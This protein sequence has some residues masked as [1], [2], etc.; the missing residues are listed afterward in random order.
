MYP[1]LVTQAGISIMQRV[2]NDILA[3][4][5]DTQEPLT[6]SGEYY[7]ANRC[8][9]GKD[10]LIDSQ[11]HTRYGEPTYY[12]ENNRLHL[13][14]DLLVETDENTRIPFMFEAPRFTDQHA[15]ALT[16]ANWIKALD[17]ETDLKDTSRIHK[18]LLNLAEHHGV[19]SVIHEIFEV[20]GDPL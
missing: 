5:L 1:R 12:C 19:S 9:N 15:A 7:E 2:V 11:L 17:H 16:I 13:A 4:D 6:K 8:L 14:G 20:L 3:D 18:R 10:E